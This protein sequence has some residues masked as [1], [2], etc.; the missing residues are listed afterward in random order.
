MGQWRHLVH[1]L[2]DVDTAGVG[3]LPVV[4]VPAGVE[5]DTVVLDRG[6]GLTW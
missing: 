3:Q 6:A 1:D 5:Q 2:V 4:A